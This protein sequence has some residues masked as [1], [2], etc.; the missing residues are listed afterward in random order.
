MARSAKSDP[1][2]NFKFRVTITPGGTALNSQASKITNLGFAVVSGLS[3][4]NEMAG[5]REGGMNTHPH[6]ILGQSDFAP[7]N[8]SRGVFSEQADLYKWQTFLHAWTQS[9]SAT[10]TT[11]S[12]SGANDYRADI[13]VAVYDHPVSSGSYT[14]DPL[15]T[16][17]GVIGDVKWGFKLFNCWPGSYS[18]SDLSAGDSGI[19]IQQLTV[20]HEGFAIAWSNSEYTSLLSQS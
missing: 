4:T 12:A 1:I 13:A 14:Q 3:V 16:D 7:V 8:F 2:R 6:K 17:N 5:Y 15:T 10:G 20:H 11:G 19:M 9:S 18:L